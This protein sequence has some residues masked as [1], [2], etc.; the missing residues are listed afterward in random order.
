MGK[1]A[2]M[3]QTIVR[4]RLTEVTDALTALGL[5]SEILRDAILAGETARDACTAND[6][7][8]AAGFDAWAR[9]VRSLRERLIAWGW[10]RVD[11]DGLPIIIS[12][13]GSIAIAVATGDE[14]TG[15]GDAPLKTKYPKGPATI[16]VVAR[17]RTQL[18]FWDSDEEQIAIPNPT[19][20]TWFLLRNR[21]DDSVYA[22]LSL[23][24]AIGDDGR[25]EEWAERIVLAP[26]S[27]DPRGGILAPPSPDLSGLDD[28]G[29]AIDVP[30]RRRT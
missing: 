27:L 20:Q 16:A 28:R 6:P 3:R 7:S 9:T 12:S 23:P 13:S 29:D 21:V 4:E 30:V 2:E 15:K 1:E 17:N 11:A 8:N 26:I 10:T 22:E 25:V 14:G 18:E 24:A 19:P 5:N